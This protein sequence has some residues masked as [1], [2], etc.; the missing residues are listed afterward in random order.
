[1]GHNDLIPWKIWGHL[2][3]VF[4]VILCGSFCFGVPPFLLSS[5]VSWLIRRL[6]YSDVIMAAMGSQIISLT[7]VLSTVNSCTE[8]IKTPRHRPLWGE[9]T[10]DP[11]QRASNAKK[12]FHL[13]TSSCFFLNRCYISNLPEAFIEVLANWV[14]HASC[15]CDTVGEVSALLTICVAKPYYRRLHDFIIRRFGDLFATNLNSKLTNSIKFSILGV[16]WGTNQRADRSA[17]RAEC[18]D[19]C[20]Y[21]TTNR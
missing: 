8:N 3:T 14:S 6:R 9:F 12:C 17:G 13:M 21:R 7:I 16:Q 1:M 5:T 11:L 18:V 15:V 4:L 19:D 2:S 20:G 10:D